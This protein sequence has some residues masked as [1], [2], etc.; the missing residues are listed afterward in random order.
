MVQ[1]M[2]NRTFPAWM[3]LANALTFLEYQKS[4]GGGGVPQEYAN[5]LLVLPAL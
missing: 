3:L 4:G 1:I 5:I 2:E